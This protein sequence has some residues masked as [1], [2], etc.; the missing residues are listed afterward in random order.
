MSWKE[1]AKTH[2]LRRRAAEI[3]CAVPDMRVLY[4]YVKKS[5][6]RSG[7]YVG[8]PQRFYNYVAYKM[9]K[10]VLWAGRNWKGSDAHIWTRFGHVRGHD[11]RSTET[12]IVREAQSDERVPHSMEQGLKWVSADKYDESQAADLLGGFL[13]AAVWPEP[14]FGY[15]EPSYLLKVWPLIRNSD[16]CAIPLGIMP[17][18]SERVLVDEAWFPCARCPKRAVP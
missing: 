12:Y 2:D 18:P 1:H 10:S 16:T 11:H 7:S 6:L 15:V 4:V 14:K 5:E 13:R 9:Y 17:M 8:D 3:L